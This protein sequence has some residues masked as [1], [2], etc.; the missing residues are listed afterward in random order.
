M[1]D[2][3][4]NEVLD[5][6]LKKINFLMLTEMDDDDVGVSA[7]APPSGGTSLPTVTPT[8][9]P[10]G[11]AG[12]KEYMEYN[13]IVGAAIDAELRNI[14]TVYGNCISNI[15]S[16]TRV[17]TVP[18]TPTYPAIHDL[19]ELVETRVASSAT[20]PIDTTPQVDDLGR[21]F[22]SGVVDNMINTGNLGYAKTTAHIDNASL[23][24]ALELEIKK[25]F[26][27]FKPTLINDLNAWVKKTQDHLFTRP[28]RG[29]SKGDIKKDYDNG[30]GSKPVKI[31]KRVSD[32][33]EDAD[34]YI[35]LYSLYDKN[36]AVYP[37]GRSGSTGKGTKKRRSAA[38]GRKKKRKAADGRSKRRK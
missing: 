7:S 31:I 37:D 6:L 26:D 30:P 29:T 9:V 38:D 36:T 12:T 1:H 14:T 32:I 4:M 20:T 18:A 11:T 19:I 24:A 25:A 33:K 5:G 15:T 35:T 27:I 16:S 34:L 3:R 23:K 21:I 2:G 28:T 10:T 13:P 8:Y 22:V 17:Y